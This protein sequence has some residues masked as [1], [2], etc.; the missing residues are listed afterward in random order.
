MGKIPFKD[1]GQ[2]D[3]W[4]EQIYKEMPPDQFLETVA[5]NIDFA[6]A[7]SICEPFYSPLG[8]NAYA[9]SMMLKIRF[10]HAYFNLSDRQ[11]EY[12]LRYNLAFKNL[13][14]SLPTTTALTTPPG[15]TLTAAS[16]WRF[17]RLF[18]SISLPS[19]KTLA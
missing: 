7:D 19:S 6:F 4:S 13:S 3:F 10:L 5:E 8:Q 18:F 12:G 14:V 17:I 11:L 1:F 15:K 9:P 2:L 16:P